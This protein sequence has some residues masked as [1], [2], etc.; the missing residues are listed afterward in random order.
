M[1]SGYDETVGVLAGNELRLLCSTKY[2][3]PKAMLS[4]YRDGILASKTYETV[5]SMKTAESFY[6]IPKIMPSDNKAVLRC[7]AINQAIDEPLSTNITLNVMYGPEKLNMNGVF[8]VEEGKQI[9]VLCSTEPANPSPKIRFSFN[10]IDFEPTTLTSAP[11]AATV[12]VGAY[13]VNAT[14]AYTVQKEHN[15][16]EIRC[17][18]ENKLANVQQIVSKQIRVLCKFK[19]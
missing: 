1:I 18:A 13:V 5:D 15:N 9:S 6:R 7:D 2:T 4:W 17:L 19:I 10:G 14:F 8:E 3:Y 12:A 16:K 11:T